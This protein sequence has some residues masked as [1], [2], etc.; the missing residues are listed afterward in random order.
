MPHTTTSQ[1]PLLSGAHQHACQEQS[2]ATPLCSDPFPGADTGR[3]PPQPTPILHQPHSDSTSGSTQ[4]PGAG[5][6]PAHGAQWLLHTGWRA[7]AMLG[8]AEDTLLYGACSPSSSEQPVHYLAYKEAWRPSRS[9][10]NVAMDALEQ[11]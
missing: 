7:G 5:S 9:W 10:I 1:L 2:P 11:D 3:L 8:R 6:R 4:S